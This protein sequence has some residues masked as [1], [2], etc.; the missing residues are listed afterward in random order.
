MLSQQ[1][2]QMWLALICTVFTSLLICMHACQ[3][4]LLKG[5]RD[6]R[7]QALHDRDVHLGRKH[8]KG[9]LRWNCG[10]ASCPHSLRGCAVRAVA[11]CEAVGHR[12]RLQA[13]QASS[14]VQHDGLLMPCTRHRGAKLAYGATEPHRAAQH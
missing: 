4:E 12:L 13:S 14:W 11:I 6:P 2:Q 3:P 1:T 5:K 10:W 7:H 8:V 9:A